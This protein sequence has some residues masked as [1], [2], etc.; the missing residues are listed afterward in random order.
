MSDTQSVLSSHVYQAAFD[1]FRSFPGNYFE[2]GVF[3]GVGIAELG[4]RNPDR[5][6]YAVDPF[7]ED[8][9]TVGASK[10][11]KGNPM[12][13]QKE[14]CYNNIK[15]LDNVV[16]FNTTSKNFSSMLTDEMV[17]DMNIN[18]VTI[19]GSHHYEDVVVDYHLAVKLINGKPGVLVFDD[20]AHIGVERAFNEFIDDY[21]DIIS[22]AGPLISENVARIVR[23]N[24]PNE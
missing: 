18:W 7:I 24:I 3:N 6:I 5:I 21:K 22:S 1:L 13:N 16:L 8:G 4:R 11:E 12:P 10:E 20:M 23:I 15:D 9:F 17:S 14:A 19:D 2:I